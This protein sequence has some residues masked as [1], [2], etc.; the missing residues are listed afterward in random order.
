VD[1]QDNVVELG[2]VVADADA[3]AAVEARYGPTAVEL[4]PEL[5]PVP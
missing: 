1:V 5:E 3:L 2:V 4:N